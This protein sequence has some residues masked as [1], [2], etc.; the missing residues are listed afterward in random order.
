MRRLILVLL[1]ASLAPAR[2]SAADAPAEPVAPAP[3]APD[4]APAA[5][6]PME[7]LFAQKCASCHSVGKGD[8]VGPDLKDVLDR[9]N[10]D[11]V[12]RLVAEPSAVLDVDPEARKLVIKYNGVRM[13]DL[14]LS[15]EQ[16]T[17]L[18]D[19]LG[20]C[21]KQECNLQAAFVAAIK[22]TA[23]DM[24]LGEALFLGHTGLKAGAPPCISCHTVRGSE[25]LGGGGLLAKD[26]THAFG[27]L[28][29]EGIDAALRNPPFIVMN[30]V[31]GDAPLDPA[32]VFALRAFLYQANRAAPPASETWSLAL[33]GLI[34][35]GLG[36]IVLN[37]FWAR[38]LRGVRRAL[39][40][41]HANARASARDSKSAPGRADDG[42]RS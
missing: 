31:Y 6:D 23:E 32:E 17:G 40:P 18:V 19:L 27:R 36:L 28:G 3:P 4:G 1:F 37:A 2:A 15:P 5:Q 42:S 38:R 14:G 13:P 30:R 7:A 35:A 41:V 33:A 12:E 24:A 16:V 25:G 29:D 8:R 34:L 11:W 39:V 9:R 20:R 10:R 21:S 22:A 26:L